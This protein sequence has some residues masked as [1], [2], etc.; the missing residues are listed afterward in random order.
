MRL[1]CTKNLVEDLT[2]KKRLTENLFENMTP[3]VRLTVKL[4]EILTARMRV[5]GNFIKK[6]D[7]KDEAY[8]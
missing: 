3:R 5:S 6:N 7:N 4:F 2:P 8:R 1:T